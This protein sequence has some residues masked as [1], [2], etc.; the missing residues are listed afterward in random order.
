MRKHFKKLTQLHTSPHST[1]LGFA[2]G[3]FWSLLPTPGLSIV[4]AT[5]CLLILPS[6]SKISLSI[7]FLLW[8][9]LVTLSINYLGMNLA[10]LITPMD[11]ME[12]T[13]EGKAEVILA[14]VGYTFAG[15]FLIATVMS[16]ACYLILKT[17][18]LRMDKKRL[19]K[20]IVPIH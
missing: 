5:S 16:L 6:M 17:I 19:G 4:L 10:L 3:T 15:N 2:V 9:P 7:S 13:S 14:Y 1:T 18:H 20:L 8:N 11:T 12:N